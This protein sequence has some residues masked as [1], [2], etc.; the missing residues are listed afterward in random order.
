MP[1]HRLTDTGAGGA[2]IATGAFVPPHLSHSYAEPSCQRLP[3]PRVSDEYKLGL[4]S[5]LPVFPSFPVLLQWRQSSC[6]PAAHHQGWPEEPWHTD[7][8]TASSSS[9]PLWSP[10]RS[11]GHCRRE[12]LQA[13]SARARSPPA[14]GS[15]TENAQTKPIPSPLQMSLA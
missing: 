12:T 2:S 5:K 10:L 14:V 11:R 6:L 13:A 15:N 1:V 9:S 7:T 8:C 3:D 4:R